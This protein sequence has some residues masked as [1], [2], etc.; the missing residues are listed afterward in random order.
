MKAE[1]RESAYREELWVLNPSPK[2]LPPVLN[3]T[4]TNYSSVPMQHP[5]SFDL[6][7]TLKTEPVLNPLKP[8]TLKNALKMTWTQTCSRPNLSDSP[9]CPRVLTLNSRDMNVEESR[10]LHLLIPGQ[11]S[12]DTLIET[13]DAGV[14][15]KTWLFYGKLVQ[16]TWLQT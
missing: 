16:T 6:Q 5:E 11:W 14:I 12:Q 8:K 15:A 1:R 10:C 9:K 2:V 4:R 7:I 3:N 13:R